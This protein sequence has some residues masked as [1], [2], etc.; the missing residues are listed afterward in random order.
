MIEFRNVSKRYLTTTG[1]KI[2]VDR[3]DLALPDGS[4]VGLLGRNGAGKTTLMAM[5]AGTVRPD[6]GEI[7]RSGVISWPLGF[8]GTFHGELTGA[9]NV[10]FAARI[11]GMDTDALVAYVADFAEIGDFMDMPLRSYSSGMRARV[12]FGTAMGVAFDWYLVDEITAV[13]DSR[14]KKKSLAMFRSRL[15][16]AGL[17]MVS[18][19]TE[20]IRSYCTSGLVLENGRVRYYENVEEAIAAHEANMINA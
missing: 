1:S 17:L 15:K 4:K 12:A 9:Q 13:G 14:F 2:I 11:Y 16:N 18:H 6:S 8:G 7:R 20:T 19:S 5:V 10:R 3:L